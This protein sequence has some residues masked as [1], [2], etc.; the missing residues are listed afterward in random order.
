M[1]A[2]HVQIH[3]AEG[4]YLKQSLF[5]I[6]DQSIHLHIMVVL[7][8]LLKSQRKL[9]IGMKVWL[10]REPPTPRSSY[11]RYALKYSDI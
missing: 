9:K 6:K 2:L 11:L 8:A 10:N 5:E 4:I 7:T 3:F 1:K